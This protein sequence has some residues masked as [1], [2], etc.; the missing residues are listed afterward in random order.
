M[1]L[2]DLKRMKINDLA[3]LAQDNGIDDAANMRRA[4]LI[5]GLLKFGILMDQNGISF[6]CQSCDPG[7]R[8][9]YTMLR[10]QPGGGHT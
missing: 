8:N 5:F 1:N 3:K 7:I 2:S 9:R 4:E 6:H 10:F